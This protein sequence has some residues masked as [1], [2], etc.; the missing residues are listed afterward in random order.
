MSKFYL[1]E[2]RKTIVE[3]LE[4]AMTSWLETMQKESF[5]EPDADESLNLML[6]ATAI[7]L[8]KMLARNP[9]RAALLQTFALNI[10]DQSEK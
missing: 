4:A 10:L 6:E 5:S 2:A 8:N 9:N 3:M 1:P 7:S